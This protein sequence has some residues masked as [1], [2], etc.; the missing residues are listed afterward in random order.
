MRSTPIL[1]CISLITYFKTGYN[2]QAKEEIIVTPEVSVHISEQSFE[3]PKDQIPL[4]EE[5]MK[6][7]E[8]LKDNPEKIDS[9]PLQVQRFLKE[10]LLVPEE[11]RD[12]IRLA[13]SKSLSTIWRSGRK[14]A[15]GSILIEPIVLN[16]ASKDLG[17]NKDCY[18]VKLE[19]DGELLAMA[20]ISKDT[21]RIKM[22]YASDYSD[23]K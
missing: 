2:I 15:G 17:T 11:K 14:S 1:I 12:E 3:I 9:L 10:R 23:T 16:T 8:I 6:N 22:L 19:S 18:L 21:T 4:F 20:L 5:L 7:P 13:F